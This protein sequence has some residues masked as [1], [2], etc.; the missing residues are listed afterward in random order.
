MSK[1]GLWSCINTERL[2]T[3]LPMTKDLLNSVKVAHSRYA[4]ALEQ[5]KSKSREG[6][7]DRKKK[8][9]I[10]RNCWG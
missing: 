10:G 1:D 7:Q 5:K 2:I 9:E 6:V 3:E 4:T 8:I